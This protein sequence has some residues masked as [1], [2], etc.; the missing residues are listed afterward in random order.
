MIEIGHW[1]GD[2][3]IG[4]NHKSTIGAIVERKTCF[5]II[6]PLFNEK[7]LSL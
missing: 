5:T 4:K 2:L 1:E 7:N 3:V 6:V